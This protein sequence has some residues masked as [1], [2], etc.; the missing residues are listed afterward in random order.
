MDESDGPSIQEK[1]WFHRK[2]DG[3]SHQYKEM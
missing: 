3:H 2:I 1:Q